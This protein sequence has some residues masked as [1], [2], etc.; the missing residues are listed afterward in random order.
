MNPARMRD[1]LQADVAAQ[2]ANAPSSA[3]EPLP[4][5]EWCERHIRIRDQAFSLEGHEYLRELY[6][7]DHPYLVRRKAAQIGNSLRDLLEALYLAEIRAAKALYYLSTDQDAYDFS[8]DR[9]NIAI[10]ESQHLQELVDERERGRDNVGLRHIGRGSLFC[11]GMFTR[12][13]VKAVDADVLYFDELD[14]ADQTNKRFAQDRILHSALGWVREASQPSIPDYGIDETFQLTDQRYWHLKCPG[15]G[16]WTC[17]DLELEERNGMEIPRHCLPAPK[18]AT[19]YRPGQRHYRGCLKCAAPLDMAKGQWVALYPSRPERRG[20]QIS[21]LYRDRPVPEYADPADWMMAELTGARKTMDKTRGTISILGRPYAG[22][23]APV[24]DRVLDLCEGDEG[25]LPGAQGCYMGVD[26]GDMLHITIGRDGDDGRPQVVYLETTED[27]RRLAALAALFKVRC[28]VIDAMPN[29]RSAKDVCLSPGMPRHSY[30]QYFTGSTMTKGEEG[31]RGRAV[32]TVKV[33]RTE[34]LDET[35]GTLRAG[36]LQLPSMKKLGGEQLKTYELF[37]AQ[38][39]MLVKDLVEDDKKGKGVAH[40]E[41]KK[42][43]PNHFGMAL[44]SMLI[45]RELSPIQTQGLVVLGNL[46]PK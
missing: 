46:Y 25:F 19:W 11:R 13:K 34:S 33:D 5:L 30:I 12:R 18:D 24:T 44:N 15:C 37:R 35:T 36:G 6:T 32:R 29:K 42:R 27:W 1:A 14:E 23:R 9:V 7:C 4:F 20:Y 38:C 26:Q 21:Q 41:Y 8:N 45:A 2:K 31:E 3:G 40:W 28:F 16:Q 22:D 10:D 43:V 39:K 17:M